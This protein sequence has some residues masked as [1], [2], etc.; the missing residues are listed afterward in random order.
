MGQY[1]RGEKKKGKATAAVNRKTDAI[2]A[3][4]NRSAKRSRIPFNPANGF[5][6][7]SKD[8]VEMSFW[9]S[10][11]AVSFLDCMSELYPKGLAQRWVYVAYL[12]ALNTAM[13]VGE[14]W[15]LQPMDLNE[16][17]ETIMIHRQHNR[18]T[19]DF[20]PTK[21][22]RMRTAPSLVTLRGE[23]RE[24]IECK[25]VGKTQMIFQNEQTRKLHLS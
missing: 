3:I 7:L 15:G 9:N 23:L 17:G 13:R 14:I 25:K 1:Q 18:V 4:L 5:R 24:L 11:E 16:N 12:L 20:G 2:M 8:H 21:G 19:N 22:K 6:K 10:L